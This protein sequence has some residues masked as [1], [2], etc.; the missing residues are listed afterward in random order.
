[1]DSG[2]RRRNSERHAKTIVPTFDQQL[3][4]GVGFG[5]RRFFA[6]SLTPAAPDMP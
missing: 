5:R 3:P 1:L 2:T 4:M 6:H